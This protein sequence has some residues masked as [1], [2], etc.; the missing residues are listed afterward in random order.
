MKQTHHIKTLRISKGYSQELLSEKSGLSLRTIQRIE[1]G[2]S[3]PRGD[4]LLRLATALEVAPEAL[5]EETAQLPDASFLMSLNLSAL[6]F[7]FLPLLGFYVPFILWMPKRGKLAGVD[8]SAKALL[9]FELT[10]N[11]INLV[12]VL[13]IPSLYALLI[14]PAWKGD[15][16]G[17]PFDVNEMIK[18]SF[19][20]WIFIELYH[21]VM[22]LLNAYRIY[23]G[24]DVLYSPIIRFFKR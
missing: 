23:H 11:L 9:N 16:I 18:S 8:R 24:R 13:V 2:E 14:N 12:G 15:M 7:L 5:I 19:F 17:I 6:S 21:L 22:I 3:D 20:W 4:T 10:L 1:N